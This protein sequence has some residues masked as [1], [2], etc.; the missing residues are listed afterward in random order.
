MSLFDVLVF[1]LTFGA[2]TAGFCWIL[3]G[4]PKVP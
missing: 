3:C 2:M 1:A 4:L